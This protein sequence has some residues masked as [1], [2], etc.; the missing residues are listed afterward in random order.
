MTRALSVD[1]RDRIARYVLAGHSRRAAAKVFAVSVSS[2]VRFVAR[3][4]ARGT[5][6]PLPQGGDR[7]SKL[8]AH[9]AYVLDRVAGQP[10]IS[11]SEL[12]D[13]LAVRGISLH[14]S[15]LSRFLKAHG[16]SYKKNAG[17]RRAKPSGRAGRA[18]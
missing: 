16:L 2:A 11:L 13:E 7:R 5:L 10:D 1:L 4:Q 17:G 14:P 3:Y 8:G 12:A 15:N 18:S 6:A 9:G